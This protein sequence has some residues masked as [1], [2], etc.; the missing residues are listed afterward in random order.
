MKGFTAFVCVAVGLLAPASFGAVEGQAVQA[1]MLDH[2]EYPCVNCLFGVSD[3]Y[4]CF[5][6]NSKILVGHEKIRTQTRKHEPVALM[7]RGKSVSIR[8]DDKSIWV[9]QAKGKDL[10]LTQDYTKKIFLENGRCQ[11]ATK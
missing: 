4:F 3:Y 7:E 10:K 5:D 8:Y 11:A 2:N 9:P 6:A 1:I